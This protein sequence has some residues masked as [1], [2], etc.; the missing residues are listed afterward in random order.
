[1]DT[2]SCTS[3]AHFGGPATREEDAS[4]AGVR[5][6]KVIVGSPR[7]RSL[8]SLPKEVEDGRILL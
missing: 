4:N 1:M 8:E 7:S 2:P 3:E 6:A 5:T